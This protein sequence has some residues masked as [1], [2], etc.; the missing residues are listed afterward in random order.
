MIKGEVDDSVPLENVDALGAALEKYR[1]Y[2]S[3]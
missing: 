3:K 1:T 2:F